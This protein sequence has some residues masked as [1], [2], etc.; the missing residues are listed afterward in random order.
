MVYT[1]L[2]NAILNRVTKGIDPALPPKL[3]SAASAGSG[4]GT[5]ASST[6]TESSVGG[7]ACS[8]GAAG[9]SAG[10]STGAAGCSAGGVGTSAAPSLDELELDE[11]GASAGMIPKD[12]GVLDAL[13]AVLVATLDVP[14]T[15]TRVLA[16]GEP[17]LTPE[18]PPAMTKSTQLSYVCFAAV[19]NQNH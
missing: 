1:I 18:P 16:P 19:P 11:L 14:A 5:D 17:E 8:V 9:A 6:G 12:P 2:L 4:T 10:T 13:V 3:P 15:G 7:V